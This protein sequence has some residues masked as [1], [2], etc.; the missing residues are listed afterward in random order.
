MRKFGA[1]IRKLR[2]TKGITLRKFA[3]AIG[4]T[5]TYQSKIERDE[6]PPPA[7]EKVRAMARVLGED[8][9]R[10]LALAGRVPSD[11]PDIIK[12]RPEQ[13]AALLRKARELPSEAVEKLLKQADK[14]KA[15]Q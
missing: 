9:E 15:K 8:E 1:T 2:E 3:Q 11:L 6:L 4:A 7:E 14:L 10:L 5:P 13:M 12:E